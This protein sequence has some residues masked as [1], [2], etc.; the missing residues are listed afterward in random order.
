[1]L[2][3]RRKDR[4]GKC[5]GWGRDAILNGVVRIGLIEKVNFE[6]KF[7]EV[8]EVDLWISGGRAFQAEGTASAK[9]LR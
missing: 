7:E 4:A 5:E 3:T 2:W 8:E 6:Q 1:M 9:V